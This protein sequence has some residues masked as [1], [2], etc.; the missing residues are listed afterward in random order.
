MRQINP[1][2]RT[3]LLGDRRAARRLPEPVMSGQGGSRGK[4]LAL[5]SSWLRSRNCKTKK[6]KKNSF[7]NHHLAGK[8]ADDFLVLA[9]TTGSVAPAGGAA[10]FPAQGKVCARPYGR[11]G[12]PG[13]GG[14][15]GEGNSPQ[16]A[17]SHKP[18]CNY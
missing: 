8:I 3:A 16:R 12:K 15:A 2:A 11:G 7:F 10:Q 4:S 1:T 6:K 5:E 9:E 17:G 14:G 13:A 18:G